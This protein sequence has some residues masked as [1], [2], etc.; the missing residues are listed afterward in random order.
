MKLSRYGALGS[1]IFAVLMYHGVENNHQKRRY[2]PHDL[3]GASIS[4]EIEFFHKQGYRLCRSSASRDEAGS[5]GAGLM[6]TFDDGHLNI[7][8]TVCELADRYRIR[9]VIAVCPGV[10][11]SQMPFWFEEIYARLALT[12]HNIPHPVSGMSDDPYAVYRLMMDRY[13]A[14][15]AQSSGQL[16]ESV[17]QSTKDVDD[18][19]VM[20]HP[21][22]HRHLGWKE[23]DE[24]LKRDACVIAIHTLYHDCVTHMNEQEFEADIQQ[25]QRLIERNLGIRS[26]R[27]VYPFGHYASDWESVVLAK[28]GITAS[29]IVD[30]KINN[31]A[32]GNY[33]IR[34]ITGSDL[35]RAPG[36]YRYL[37]HRRHNELAGLN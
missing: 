37:W 29:F 36:Y 11:E 15:P 19:Q 18:E 25:C 16:L 13:L 4:K 33:R 31:K 35:T 30:E 20:A 22:V 24:L 26:S 32:Q 6:I 10:I 28:C 23:L 12:R 7:A 21:A 14:D 9:P 2:R 5:L 8:Q 1:D 34:R 27:F 17:R 3:N